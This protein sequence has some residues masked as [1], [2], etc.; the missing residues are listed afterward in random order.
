MFLL[1]HE[2]HDG[3]SSVRNVALTL[4][5]E[6]VTGA[7]SLGG[8]K[9]ICPGQKNPSSRKLVEG[10]TSEG[11]RIRVSGGKAATA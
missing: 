9:S 10:G 4:V 6:K 11:Q 8:L 5:Q 3:V 1:T 2:G 7:V